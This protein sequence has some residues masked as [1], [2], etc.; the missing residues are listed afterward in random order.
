[1]DRNSIHRHLVIAAVF[2]AG[3]T[4]AMACHAGCSRP[5]SVAASPIGYSTVVSPDGKVSGVVPEFLA[6]VSQLSGCQFE[7]LPMPRNRGIAEFEAGAID[8]ITS[9]VQTEERDRFGSFVPTLVAPVGL[10]MLRD[11][12]IRDPESQLFRGELTINVVRGHDFGDGYRS[13]VEQLKRQGRVE[14][15]D[16]A[17]VVLRKMLSHRADATVSVSVTQAEV[18][19]RLGVSDKLRFVPLHSIKPVVAGFYLS[20]T[21]LPPEDRKTLTNAINSLLKRGTYSRIYMAKYPAW[22]TVGITEPPAR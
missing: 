4:C 1:M 14:E 5:I 6:F 19:E 15:V 10:I 18:A 22:A 17:E 16:N 12:D 9:A 3:G 20:L 21:H 11:N 2:V 13:I 7:Y 8:M